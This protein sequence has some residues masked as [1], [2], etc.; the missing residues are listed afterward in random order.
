MRN[1]KHLFEKGDEK[2]WVTIYMR[3]TK[4]RKSKRCQRRKYK[5]YDEPS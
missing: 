5:Y 1:L 4:Q 2:A 3:K